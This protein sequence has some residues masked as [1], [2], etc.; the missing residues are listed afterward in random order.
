MLDDNNVVRVFPLLVHL[1]RLLR[2]LGGS[3]EQDGIGSH[4]VVHDGGFGDLLGAELAFRREAIISAR[5]RQ[6][7]HTRA[8]N[9]SKSLG[10]NHPSEVEDSLL[11]VVIAQVIITRNAQRLDTRIDQ[12]LGQHTLDLCLAT[13]E[14]ITANKRLVPF[15]ELNAAGHKRVLRGAVDERRAFQDGRYGK[16]GRGGH[17]V[18]RGFD[19]GQEVVGRVV[20]RGENVGVSLGVGGPEDDDRVELVVRLEGANVGADMLEVGLLVVT[21]NQV[22]GPVGLVGSDKVGVFPSAIHLT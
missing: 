16:D 14:I 7:S 1:A 6:R 4:H 10:C 2:E 20:D 12:K 5:L 17:F 22:V 15:R 8:A 18:V 13:L 19:G 9:T 21:G 11:A 3:L